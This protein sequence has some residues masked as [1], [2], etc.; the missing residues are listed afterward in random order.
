MK[1]YYFKNDPSTTNT[2]VEFVSTL[3]TQGKVAIFPTETVY[4]LGAHAFRDEALLKIFEIKGREKNKPFTL[5]LSC[6]DEVESVAQDIPPAF[7]RLANQFLPGPLTV[8]LKKRKN[9]TSSLISKAETV[10]VR[11]TSHPIAQALIKKIGAPLAATS[12]N[13]SGEPPLVDGEIIYERFNNKVAAII[14]EGRSTIGVASTII[15]LVDSPKIIRLGS[16]SVSEIEECLNCKI[17]T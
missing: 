7:Y 17:S 5:H 13:M 9:V 1:T 14:D 6:I 16:I 12:V 3:L 8:I 11:V 15:N 4:G 2:V 10:A